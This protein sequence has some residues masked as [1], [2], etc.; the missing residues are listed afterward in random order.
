MV[1]SERRKTTG[2]TNWTYSAPNKESRGSIDSK[3]DK[4]Q[5]L[6][7]TRSEPWGRNKICVQMTIV[8]GALGVT[9][10]R[11]KKKLMKCSFK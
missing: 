3:T 4:S 8:S 7:L 6:T 2:L 9:P 1:S 11:L 10:R 5:S